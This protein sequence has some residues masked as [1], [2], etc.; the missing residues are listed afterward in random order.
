MPLEVYNSL[1]EQRLADLRADFL[2][3]LSGRTRLTLEIGCGHGHYLSAYAAAHPDEFC[4]G[5]DLIADRIDRAG[6]KTGRAKLDNIAWVQ[7]EAS[8][9]LAALPVQH[10][11]GKIFL[12]FSDPWPKRRHWKH[13]VMQSSL[14]DAL[15]PLTDQGAC[16]YFRTDHREYFEYARDVVAEHSGWRIAVP[17][18][19]QWPFEQVS[20]FQERAADKGYHSFIIVR[21]AP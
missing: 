6:R 2:P 15:M 13:R 4:V 20:V 16:L 3:R 17:E 7:A 12:L 19:A 1:R 14:L 5:I 8:L 9:F 18:E 10:R 21:I 11:L